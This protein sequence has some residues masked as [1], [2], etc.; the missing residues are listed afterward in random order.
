MEL[1]Q[2]ALLPHSEIDKTE[3]YF[4]SPVAPLLEVCDRPT[5]STRHATW[6]VPCPRSQELRIVKPQAVCRQARQ[7]LRTVK[8]GLVRDTCECRVQV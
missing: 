7:E 1:M 3:V 8:L 6:L 2:L 4:M 5:S